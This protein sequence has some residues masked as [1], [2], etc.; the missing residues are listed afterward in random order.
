M[1]GGGDVMRHEMDVG[2]VLHVVFQVTACPGV[3]L[4]TL[5]ATVHIGGATQL[6]PF[7]RVPTGH[8]QVVV[9]THGPKIGLIES[10]Q[11]VR[12]SIVEGI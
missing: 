8:A 1:G 10:A 7:H 9:G 6:V 5:G 3:L 2:G 11:K 12:V 4:S